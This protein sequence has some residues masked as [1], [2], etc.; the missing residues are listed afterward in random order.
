MLSERLS[1]SAFDCGETFVVGALVILRNV[2]GV[3]VGESW[4]LVGGCKGNRSKHIN[5]HWWWVSL[6]KKHTL[7]EK[8]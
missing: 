1:A 2:V 7:V 3:T 5:T 6:L 4:E 8:K